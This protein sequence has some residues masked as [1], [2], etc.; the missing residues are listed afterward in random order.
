M[1]LHSVG[2]KVNDDMMEKL[3][4]QYVKPTAVKPFVDPIKEFARASHVESMVRQW[5]TYPIE[6]RKRLVRDAFGYIARFK[7]DER[8]GRL[9]E[10]EKDYEARQLERWRGLCVIIQ[11]ESRAKAGNRSPEVAIGALKQLFPEYDWKAKAPA[12][13][14]L[15]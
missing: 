3:K 8:E 10:N 15:K 2:Q 9:P 6:E 7:G 5:L 13:P 11:E 1:H 12:A 14:P 4:E